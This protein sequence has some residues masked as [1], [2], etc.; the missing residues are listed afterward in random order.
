MKKLMMILV[1]MVVMS[2]CTENARARHFGGT[3]TLALKP[4]EVV[5]NVTWKESQMW[6]CTQDTVTRVVYFREKSS[7]GVVEGTVIIK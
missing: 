6:I 5:L 1:A 7:W 4:N 2:S 3:E